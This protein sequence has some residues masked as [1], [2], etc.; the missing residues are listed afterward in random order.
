MN[1]AVETAPVAQG[2][3]AAAKAAWVC[4]GIAWLTFLLPVPGIGIFIGWPLNLVG[5]IL[6]IVAMA[7]R[8]AGAGLFQLIASL[9]VSP[10][11]YFV[12]LAVLAG[13]IGAAA[14]S[15]KATANTAQI[16]AAADAGPAKAVSALELF[17]AYE[18]N[19]IAADQAYKDQ[20][21]EV[22][23]VIEG[24]DSDLSDEPVVKLSAGTFQSVHVQ[25]LTQTV[26]ASLSKGQQITVTCIG[27]GEV[28]GS[29]ILKNCTLN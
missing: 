4:L 26:A 10:I 5:F 13:S 22:S 23:G 19:E 8:G 18:A 2:T 29:P 16:E 9:I 1:T 20:R 17:N 24:I 6:A 12:G 7:K 28:V 14:E 3:N 15:A 21:L 11:V 27:G 25:D